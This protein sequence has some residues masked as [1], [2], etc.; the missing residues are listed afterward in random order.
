MY[1]TC[2]KYMNYELRHLYR[3]RTRDRKAPQ[4]DDGCKHDTLTLTG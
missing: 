2:M 1:D 4:C 3:H